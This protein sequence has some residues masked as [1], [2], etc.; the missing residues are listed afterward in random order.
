MKK[1]V[2]YLFAM[3]LFSVMLFACGNRDNDRRDEFRK[4]E[5]RLEQ[6]RENTPMRADSLSRDT[7]TGQPLDPSRP[8]KR[9][10]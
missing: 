7:I 3:M 4:P 2:F 8:S 1:K 10:P 9:Q 5:D 6:R